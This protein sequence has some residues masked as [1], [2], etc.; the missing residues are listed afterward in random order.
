MLARSCSQL[1]VI[2]NAKF[3]ECLSYYNINASELAITAQQLLQKLNS[4]PTSQS[5]EQTLIQQQQSHGLSQS[6]SQKLDSVLKSTSSLVLPQ[7]PPAPSDVATATNNEITSQSVQPQQAATQQ[8]NKVGLPYPSNLKVEKR[9]EASLLVTWDP[10]TAP[11][12]ISQSIDVDN[13]ADLNEQ[14]ITVQC[15]NLYLNNELR[16]VISGIDDRVAVLD[17]IDLNMVSL[18]IKDIDFNEEKLNRLQKRL[19]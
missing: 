14:L 15:Y 1:D 10:P 19:F 11:L 18:M 16:C 9:S 17:D 13:L 8:Q 2:T 5:G 12:P 7:N 6:K 4:L 3:N